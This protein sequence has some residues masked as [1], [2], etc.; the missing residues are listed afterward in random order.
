[1]CNR[2]LTSET[3]N[4][5]LWR[6]LRDKPNG[7][8]GW[9]VWSKAKWVNINFV[10]TSV[11]ARGLTRSSMSPWSG[12]TGRWFAKD[13]CVWP[14]HDGRGWFLSIEPASALTI[15]VNTAWSRSTSATTPP[16]PATPPTAASALAAVSSIVTRGASKG[17]KLHTRARVSGEW[18][19]E[20][21]TDGNSAALKL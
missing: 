4:T 11:A 7:S 21:V 14:Q 9:I 10:Q 13:Y 6:S 2:I 18:S 1:M 15:G 19:T 3:K 5:D 16:P 8:R 12:V 17:P 20:T